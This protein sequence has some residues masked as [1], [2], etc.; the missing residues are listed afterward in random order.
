MQSHNGASVASSKASTGLISAMRGVVCFGE[1]SGPSSAAANSHSTRVCGIASFIAA[2]QVSCC[3]ASIALNFSCRCLEGV[4]NLPC[5]ND[6]MSYLDLLRLSGEE[7]EMPKCSL[8]E[9][10][11]TSSQVAPF[12]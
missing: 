9:S 3:F 7:I 10:E 6:S 11:T 4:N 5:N 8:L 1:S 2:I 12:R